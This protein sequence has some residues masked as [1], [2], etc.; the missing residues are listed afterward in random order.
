MKEIIADYS[1]I[2]NDAWHVRKYQSLVNRYFAVRRN[3]LWHLHV[4]AHPVRIDFSKLLPGSMPVLINNYNRLAPLQQQIAWLSSLKEDVSILIVDNKSNYPPLL[5]YYDGLNAPN[6]QVIKLG[7]NSWRK[8]ITHVAAMLKGFS[9][10]IITDPDLLP[11]D[12]TPNDVVS[13][14]SNLLDKY[15]AINH[16]GL[17]LEI[18]DL[19]ESPLRDKV[20]NHESQF[21]PPVAK[22]LG[23]GEVFVAA[24]DTTFAMYRNTSIVEA[25]APSLR[26]SRPYTL[27]HIDWY[28]ASLMSG[29]YQ[30]YLNTA[31]SGASWAVEVKR[32]VRSS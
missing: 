7:F 4:V 23:D 15:P 13:H 29:E 21:W 11:Y 16:I 20:L 14:L 3:L 27:K 24:I 1:I 18:N 19:P 32:I 12:T 2:K 30:F 9:K 6:I 8:G 22:A 26:T 28:P 31:T 17:S 10:F 5:A 25:L